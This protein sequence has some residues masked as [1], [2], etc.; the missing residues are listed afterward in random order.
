MAQL[1]SSPVCQL[2]FPP[3][4]TPNAC[5]L[6]DVA[7]P[8][9]TCPHNF[10]A[11][12]KKIMQPQFRV[13]WRFRTGG[14]PQSCIHTCCGHQEILHIR[15]TCECFW[16]DREAGGGT[17]CCRWH[18]VA[19]GIC[20]IHH[21]RSKRS[22]FSWTCKKWFFPFCGS[23]CAAALGAAVGLLWLNLNGKDITAHPY[24]SSRKN[25]GTKMHV[26]KELKSLLHDFWLI[27]AQPR[28]SFQDWRGCSFAVHVQDQILSN[29][30]SR[31]NSIRCDPLLPPSS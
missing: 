23:C 14:F 31:S 30:L 1:I 16:C 7:C 19:I 9:V 27:A 17:A 13:L 11:K 28:D 29:S 15:Q 10:D 26:R 5:A 18:R 2:A 22:R 21:T 4:W 6:L 24:C 3:R 12:K 25:L 8:A 20:S